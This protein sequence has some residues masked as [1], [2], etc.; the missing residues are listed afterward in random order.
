MNAIVVEHVPVTDLPQ[1]WR[2]TLAQ[3]ADAHVTVH[4]E[5][6][7]RPATP[8]D[9][10]FATDDPAF[11]IWRAHEDIADVAAYIRRLRAPRYNRDG[12]RDELL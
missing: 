9:K 10:S 1:E 6:E 4:I 3:A 8:A 2:D 7:H 12:S 5:T 11:G